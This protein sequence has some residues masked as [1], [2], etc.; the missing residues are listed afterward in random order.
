M[1]NLQQVFLFAGKVVCVGERE[2]FMS[3]P[4]FLFC[5]EALILLNLVKNVQHLFVPQ[6]PFQLR[7][8]MLMNQSESSKS[9]RNS[10]WLL[11]SAICS[12]TPPP[13]S[14]LLCTPVQTNSPVFLFF[15]PSYH[16]QHVPTSTFRIAPVPQAQKPSRKKCHPKREGLS[17]SFVFKAHGLHQSAIVTC[18][19][20]SR[21]RA[22]ASRK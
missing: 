15:S 19:A 18:I 21:T 9:F 12:L 11:G 1:N 22:G 6:F 2:S 20:T 5:F 8:Q 14:N 7:C 10:A 4:N 16:T 17:F 3:G 13:R